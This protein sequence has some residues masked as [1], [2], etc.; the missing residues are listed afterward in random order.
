MKITDIRRLA[1]SSPKKS[2]DNHLSV[3]G[4]ISEG[5][6]GITHSLDSRQRRRPRKKRSK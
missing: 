2:S 3:P 1:R 6:S 4:E 5:E